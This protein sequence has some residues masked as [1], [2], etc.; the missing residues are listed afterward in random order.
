MKTQVYV[1]KGKW[2]T[3]HLAPINAIMFISTGIMVPILDI[4]RPKFPFT[5][6]AFCIGGLVVI[7]LAMKALH[8]PARLQIPNGLVL[9][10]LFCTAIFS[11]GAFASYKYERE[12]GLLASKIKGLAELQATL[13]DIKNGKSDNPRVELANMGIKWDFLEFTKL[14]VRGDVK[15][16]RLFIQGGMPLTDGKGQ[17]FQ[18][19]PFFVARDGSN[20]VAVLE[21]MRGLLGAGL[22]PEYGLP[23][24]H[25]APNLYAVAMEANRTQVAEKL[26]EMGVDGS[27]YHQW[28]SAKAEYDKKPK[29]HFYGI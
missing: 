16:V 20:A 19:V 2:V 13:L 4:M 3:D 5:E 7:L 8:V 15:A 6:V 24:E 12:G 9:M 1:T 28:K 22:V 23:R 25:V 29:A 18:S 21:E 27:G 26:A 11:A 14:A 10:A 17:Y